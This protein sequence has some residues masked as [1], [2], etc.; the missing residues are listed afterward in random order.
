M[1]NYY[2][3]TR[4]ESY[5]TLMDAINSTPTTTTITWIIRLGTEFIVISHT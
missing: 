4:Y 3:A 5:K 2:V 1:T